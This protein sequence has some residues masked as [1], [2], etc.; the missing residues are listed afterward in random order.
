MLVLMTCTLLV[1]APITAIGGVFL[2]LREDAGLSALLLI[3]IPALII[4]VGIVVSRMVPQFRLM[5]ERID[6]VNRVLREQIT[7]IRV[8]RAFVREPD[9]SKRFGAAQPGPHRHLDASRPADGVHV[10]DRHR[11]PEPVERRRDLDR[12]QPDRQ[13]VTD[14]RRADRLP[15]LPHPDPDRRD[16]G[17]VHGDHGAPSRRVRRADPGG[18]GH[19]VVGAS[20]RP[21]RS[22]ASTTHGV[23]RAPRRR[24]PLP[25]GRGAGAVA[26]SRSRRWPGKTT[27][28]IG[29]TGAGKT[30]L[31]N[32][33]PRLFDVTSGSVLVDGVDV[34]ELDP[35]VLL[36]PDR[37]GAPEAVPL[38]GHRG[39]QPAL[40]EARRHRRGAVGGVGGGPGHRLRGAPCPAAST[41]AS[42][43]A[44]PTCRVVSASASPSPGP[45]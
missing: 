14:R 43:R 37:P 11:H 39:Q 32:L 9:E 8:V 35:D 7:G 15:E 5:Q 6:V 29:S 26:T 20:S 40:R 33:V 22:P 30:T 31:V 42:P 10:P 21:C 4:S 45:S 12:C 2:A 13:R 41:P 34:R 16:D 25:R 1:A 3:S 23:A 27:A 17:H 36:Q 28:I 18:P 19:A 38:L 44:A 24:V